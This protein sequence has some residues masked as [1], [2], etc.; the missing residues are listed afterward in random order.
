MSKKLQIR[1]RRLLLQEKEGNVTKIFAGL[2]AAITGLPPLTL[3][4]QA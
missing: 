1:V 3:P 2:T 4:G